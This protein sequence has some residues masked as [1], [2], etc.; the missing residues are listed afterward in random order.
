[1]GTRRWTRTPRAESKAVLQA[2]H[3]SAQFGSTPPPQFVNLTKSPSWSR[4]PSQLT[5]TL[6]L[7]ESPQKRHACFLSTMPGHHSTSPSSRVKC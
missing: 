5:L 3:S 4:S 7:P 1:M 2:R 6:F